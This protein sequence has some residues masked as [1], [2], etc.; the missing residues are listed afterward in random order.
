MGRP[1]PQPDAL[2]QGGSRQL[3]GDGS[4]PAEFRFQRQVLNGG[5]VICC[6]PENSP[7]RNSGMRVSDVS[8]S[9]PR[10]GLSPG[11]WLSLARALC[12]ALRVG[13]LA[14]ELDLAG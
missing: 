8:G 14:D 10:Y 9:G 6:N 4:E 2:G 13:H 7:S 3:K 5:K 11:M 12:A 1:F